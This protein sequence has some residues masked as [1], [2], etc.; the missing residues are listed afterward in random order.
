MSKSRSLSLLAVAALLLVSAPDAPA[1]TGVRGGGAF[2]GGGLGAVRYGTG[3]RG[4]TTRDTYT[5]SNPAG[6]TRANSGSVRL[7]SRP[8]AWGD[9][10]IESGAKPGPAN[11][12]GGAGAQ[13]PPRAASLPAVGASVGSLPEGA[14]EQRIKGR[15]YE[16]HLG[17]FYRPRFS[18]G[19][20][21]Y[22]VVEAPVGALLDEP[23]EGATEVIVGGVTYFVYADTWWKPV[24]TRGRERFIVV[25]PPN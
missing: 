6:A 17:V 13:A 1:Q 14:A 22:V 16:Y 9:T 10:V 19:A 23:P 20:V 24:T 5:R 4:T 18:F 2:G 3:V 7:G 21:D 11:R 8:I 15:R 25:S 12:A